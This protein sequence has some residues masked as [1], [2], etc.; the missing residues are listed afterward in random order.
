[1]FFYR[2]VQFVCL[3]YIAI[4]SIFCIIWAG[5]YPLEEC[6]QYVLP[7]TNVQDFTNK[8][9]SIAN[10]ESDVKLNR[11]GLTPNNLYDEFL[12]ATICFDESDELLQM[13]A[14]E[15]NHE[16]I[17]RIWNARDFKHVLELQ[18]VFERRVLKREGDYNKDWY[19]FYTCIIVWFYNRH[20]PELLS[21]FF[22]AIIL[23]ALS[24]K[25]RRE[26]WKMASFVLLTAVPFMVLLG[27]L[28][29]AYLSPIFYTNKNVYDSQS[30]F[31]FDGDSGLHPLTFLIVRDNSIADYLDEH[32][33]IDVNTSDIVYG[34]SLLMFA[35]IHNSPTSVNELLERHADPNYISPYSGGTPLLKAMQI[36]DGSGTPD[37]A[38]LLTLLSSSADA[39]LATFDKRHNRKRI[40]LLEVRSLEQAHLLVERGRAYVNDEIIHS[41]EQGISHYP[42]MNDSTQEQIIDYYKALLPNG[43]GIN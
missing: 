8:L 28:L 20:F 26:R 23:F 31:I 30:R 4:T 21:G 32:K 37:T 12:V 24:L 11:K 34:N 25:M 22:L 2:A 3:C 10:K 16:V 14:M 19:Y 15:H 18:E 40:P 29:V 6:I 7:D 38:L 36:L 41:L 1:M 5:N 17:V 27:S 35:I 13:K 9:K 39:N 42:F 33:N 43:R